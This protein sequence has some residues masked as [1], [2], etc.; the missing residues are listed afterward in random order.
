[1]KFQEMTEE[2]K[3]YHRQKKNDWSKRKF[4]EM[5]EEEKRLKKRK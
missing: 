5:T 3:D 1:M 4:Q 2:E